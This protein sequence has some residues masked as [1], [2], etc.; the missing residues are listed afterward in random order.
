MTTDNDVLDAEMAN[1]I[2]DD[3]H[4][5]EISVADQVGDIA[6]DKSLTGLEAGDLLSRDTGVA[7]SDP[8]IFGRLASGQFGKVAGVLFG[9]FSG[10]GAVMFEET[11][12]RLAEVFGNFLGGRGFAVG[13]HSEGS[14]GRRC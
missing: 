12:V 14:K 11:V 3:A 7:A 10:P 8:E 13:S 4:N 9:L 2:V 1:C 5:V 6:V